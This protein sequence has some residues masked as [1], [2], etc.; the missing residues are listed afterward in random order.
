MHCRTG[1]Q[2][3]TSII[4]L[5]LMTWGHTGRLSPIIEKRQGFHQLL[6]PSPNNLAFPNIL[7]KSAPVSGDMI[8]FSVKVRCRTQYAIKT[9]QMDSWYT[10]IKGR[11]VV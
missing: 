9:R 11:T 7:D 4:S 8:V 2:C 10:S 3:R 5:Y 1:S 6:A